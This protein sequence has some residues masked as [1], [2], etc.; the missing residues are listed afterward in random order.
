MLWFPKKLGLSTGYV[1]LKR[2]DCAGWI[3]L[4]R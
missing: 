1:P 3:K 2:S 4:Y